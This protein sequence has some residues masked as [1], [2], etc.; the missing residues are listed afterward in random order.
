MAVLQIRGG[1]HRAH[2]IFPPNLLGAASTPNGR[3][4]SCDELPS[5]TGPFLG[6]LD[7]PRHEVNYY[8]S[9]HQ[10]AFSVASVRLP[11]TERKI[12]WSG[13]LSADAQIDY[14]PMMAWGFLAIGAGT[15]VRATTVSDADSLLYQAAEFDSSSVAFVLLY[16]LAPP[17][18]S[19]EG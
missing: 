2:E 17:R 6:A 13:V 9:G 12:H 1:L 5:T 15:A 8:S 4:G 10:I 7:R 11:G 19:S 18:R 14:M 3:N 16:V